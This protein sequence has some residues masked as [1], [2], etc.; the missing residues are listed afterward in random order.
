MES[1]LPDPPGQPAL[2]QNMHSTVSHSTVSH[3]TVCLNM[4]VKDESHIIEKTLQNILDKIPI[5]YWVISDTGSTDNTKEII[6]S[7]FQKKQIPG[8]LV[9]HPWQDFAYNRSKALECAYQKTDYLFIFDADDEI[10]GNLVLPNPLTCEMYKLIFGPGLFYERPL[11]ISNHKRW[12]FKGVLHEFLYSLEPVKT[13]ETIQ[14]NYHIVSGRTG[15]RSKDPLKYY[16]DAVTLKIAF[17]KEEEIGMK[18]RYAFYCA[19]SYKDAGPEY[20]DQ[21]IE[22]YKKCLELPNW[23]QEKFYSCLMIGNFY[24]T[25]QDPWNSLKYWIQS[26]NYDHERIEG[27]ALAMKHLRLDEQ[28]LLVHSLYQKFKNYHYSPSNKLFLVRELYRDVIQ[29][30]NS[31]SSFYVNDHSSGYECCKYLLI[32][33]VIDYALMKNTLSNLH[34]YLG[35]IEQDMDTLSLFHAVN[36]LLYE[37]DQHKEPI[38]KTHVTIWEMLLERNRWRFTSHLLN[39][40]SYQMIQ[41]LKS[42]FKNHT[43]PVIFLSFT[44]CKRF[45]LFQE[46]IHSILNHWRDLQKIDYWFC[47]DDQS[48]E[49][50]RNTMKQLYPWI[51]YVMKTPEERGHR[52]SMNMIWNKL[53][54]LRPK[55]WIHLEDDFLFYYPMNYIEDALNGL[56]LMKD[57][58]VRQIV[59]NRNYAETIQD[60]QIQGHASASNNKYC[61]H[62]HK[63]SETGFPYINCHYWPHFSFRPSMICVDTILELGNFDSANTFFEM[64]YANRW[65]QAGYQTAFFNR[66]THRHIGRLTTERHDTSIHNAYNMNHENQ[67]GL[68]L[69]NSGE[70]QNVSSS[71]P[72][73]PSSPPIPSIQVQKKEAFI[74]ILNLKRRPDRREKITEELNKHKVPEEYYEWIS[75]I[76]GKELT[77]TWEL[78]KLFQG[79]DFGNRIGFIGCALSHYSL[80]KELVKDPQH[81]FY[82]IMEDDF[83]LCPDFKNKMEHLKYS[84][85][86]SPLLLLGYHMFEKEREKVK[87]TYNH[88]FYHTNLRPLDKKL[89]I[90]GFFC[91]SINKAG[92]KRLCDY[93][94]QYGIRH[95]IDYLIKIVPNLPCLE[96]QPQLAFSVWDEKKVPSMDTDIQKTKERMDFSMLSSC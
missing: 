83:T 72:D 10:Q 35:Q 94:E 91:Y 73:L 82:M 92:A 65:T 63:K 27:I 89:Y 28:H 30:E 22:W 61:I 2:N 40:P 69:P 23:N 81:Q 14:G 8:E 86:Q 16:K 39:S 59:F 74:K 49:E 58:R 47:V 11:L 84:M 32:H 31:I 43:E 90:G 48:S 52:K 20:I 18:C 17:E 12:N 9:E 75:S 68:S 13:Q 41:S 93:I 78:K 51:D 50:E 15:A 64:D 71:K 70:S 79:N 36:D 7:F 56:N 38:E 26:W 1:N 25:K 5:H 42:S 54:E 55:Y 62:Q 57:Q 44:T 19:Q 95:G 4:I 45:K 77:P 53:K 60:Y 3:S 6:Q 29:Y 67:F 88:S 24:Q 96:C 34:C 85:Y 21:S 80:W 33:K 37:I 76:D 66:I 87:N 46:T